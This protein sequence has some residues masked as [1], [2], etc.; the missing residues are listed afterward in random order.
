MASRTIIMITEGPTKSPVKRAPLPVAPRVF[1][2]AVVTDVQPAQRERLAALQAKY[3]N[4][5]AR[6]ILQAMVSEEFP[7]RI[8]VVSSF[9]SESVVLLHLLSQI[10]PS[11]P[12]IFLNTGKL[13]GETLR[14]RDRLQD[15]LGLLDVRAIGPR[16]SDLQA[17]DPQG[18]LWSR[19][20]DACCNIRKVLPL[21][22]ALLGFD[23][24]ITGR[25]RFQTL[26][27]SAIAPVELNG[28]RFVVNPLWNWSLNDLKQHILDNKLPRHPLVEDGFLSIGCMP[29]TQRVKDEGDYRSG[30][31][32]GT[33]KD[34][35]GI[36]A[37]LDGDGI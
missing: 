1:D 14:Y 3:Q 33:D 11:V 8:A 29:C 2:R 31:W 16:L 18:I 35:C 7:G 6:D 23:A 15:V 32:A 30:R 26:S 5:D 21:Q 12:V 28:S 24:E 4:S 27:R 9:G 36:H 25:K 17:K 19:D 13:F 37:N 20:P 10:D 34:E 22:R